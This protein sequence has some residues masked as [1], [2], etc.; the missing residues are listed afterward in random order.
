M[1]NLRALALGIGLGLGLAASARAGVN[2]DP[3]DG[4][5]L[6]PGRTVAVGY[7][8]LA[9]A[10][11]YQLD[12]PGFGLITAGTHLTRQ[13]GI[14][15]L[16][17]YAALGGVEIAPQLILPYG[18]LY[19]GALGGVDLPGA[20]GFADPILGLT[21]WLV[22]D[23]AHRRFV[24]VTEW[25]TLPVGGYEP[26]RVLN[27][28]GNRWVGDLQMGYWQGLA[29][30]VALDIAFDAT[31]FGDNSRAGNGRQTL[32]QAP[33]YQVQTWLEY[34]FTRAFS[35]ALGYSQT[36]G[37]RQKLAGAYDGQETDEG[38]VRIA[39]QQFLSHNLQLE[40]IAAHDVTVMG[41][42]RQNFLMQLRLVAA[43]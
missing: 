4:V 32:T 36:F 37:G 3:G 17:H 11:G 25:V 28:G 12:L 34:H 39:V 26:G 41:G 20:T 14:F 6:A 24:G 5:T 18:S 9:T 35:T 15:R 29:P 21:E 30:R 8:Q 33:S 1:P 19:N 27:L 38:A 10:D 22:N 23:H 7:Y 42:F 2:V 43:F 31:F 40:A 16:I 13:L